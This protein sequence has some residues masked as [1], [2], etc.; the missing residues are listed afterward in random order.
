VDEPP[1]QER[2]NYDHQKPCPV[3][4]TKSPDVSVI[5]SSG[6]R[7]TTTPVWLGKAKWERPGSRWPLSLKVRVFLIFPAKFLILEINVVIWRAITHPN[8]NLT[9]AARGVM[10]RSG[11]HDGGGAHG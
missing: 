1:D 4:V 8:R 9:R 2:H 3:H 7:S 11:G 5:M 10:A 6:R